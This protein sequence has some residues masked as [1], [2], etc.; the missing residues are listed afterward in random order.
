[1]AVAEDILE[2]KIEKLPPQSVEAE[3]AVL[4]LCWPIPCVQ[5]SYRDI[6]A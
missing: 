2:N 5:Q 6:E 3:Q 1:M 4:G